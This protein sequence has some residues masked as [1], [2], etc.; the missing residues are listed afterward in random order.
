MSRNLENRPPFVRVRR[1]NSVHQV[2]GHFRVLSAI[3]V[4]L[5][6]GVTARSER[7]FTSEED[8]END[9]QRPDVARS[10]A[11]VVPLKDFG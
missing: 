5:L 6:D 4:S 1:Q 9:S 7:L 3:A 11:I 2:F 10:R 8:S